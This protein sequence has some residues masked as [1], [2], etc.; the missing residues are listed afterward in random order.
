MAKLEEITTFN[1]D[2]KT[3]NV[4]S[5]STE[6]KD[7]LRVYL[8][9][10]D[11]IIKHKV[12]LVKSQHALASMGNMFRDLIKDVEPVSQEEMARQQAAQALINATNG[13]P[14]TKRVTKKPAPRK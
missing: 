10:E 1:L 9:T 11:D 8:E 13:A 5:L 2:N 6:A 4:S 12:A 14:A 7:L 3:Y